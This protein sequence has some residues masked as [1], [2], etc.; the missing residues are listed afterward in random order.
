MAWE[1]LPSSQETQ[2]QKWVLKCKYLRD[3]NRLLTGPGPPPAAAETHSVCVWGLFPA[4]V[5]EVS[6]FA[7]SI[8]TP[9]FISCTRTAAILKCHGISYNS[10]NSIKASQWEPAPSPVLFKELKT[11]VGLIEKWDRMGYY[12]FQ[13]WTK[14]IRFLHVLCIS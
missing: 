6:L 13:H 8:W 10:K 11:D 5:S 7:G 2:D 1:L 4:I 3:E 9:L 14:N 12:K